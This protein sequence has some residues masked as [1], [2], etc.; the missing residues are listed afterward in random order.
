MPTDVGHRSLFD[1][2]WGCSAG[3]KA[4]QLPVREEVLDRWTQHTLVPPTPFL[5]GPPLVARSA[6]TP[7]NVVTLPCASDSEGTVRS[8]WA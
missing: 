1:A 5:L 2:C 4:L 7:T 6:W 3:G 8:G